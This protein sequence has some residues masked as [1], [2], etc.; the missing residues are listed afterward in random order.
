MLQLGH[1]HSNNSAHVIAT[2]QV[3]L[4][5]WMQKVS[6]HLATLVCQEMKRRLSSGPLFHCSASAFARW[7]SL[8]LCQHWPLSD[9]QWLPGAWYRIAR[10][11]AVNFI[12]INFIIIYSSDT[13]D[14]REPTDRWRDQISWNCDHTLVFVVDFF[15]HSFVKTGP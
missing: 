12:A 5:L 10:R 6:Y 8:L 9:I 14:A 2:Y 3:V 1:R 11:T 15:Y 13:R 7:C 4:F